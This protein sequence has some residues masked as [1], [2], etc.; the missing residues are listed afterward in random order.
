VNWKQND[1]WLG[2]LCEVSEE[3]SARSLKRAKQ[4]TLSLLCWLQTEV[5][6]PDGGAGWRGLR[7]HKDT[8]GTEDGLAKYR[9]IR[10][11]RRIKA[12]FAVLEKHVGTEAR[13]RLTGKSR[14]EVTAETFADSVSVGSYRI[15][16]RPSS[17]ET[18]YIVFGSLP[19]QISLGAL[20]PERVEN[21][22]VECK[23]IEK[24]HIT[25]G[26]YR[27]HPPE[28]NIG[29]SAGSLDTFCVGKKGKPRQVRNTPSLLV[30]F[31]RMI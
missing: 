10:E 5:P 29:E 26:C 13:M 2:N 6:R 21:P 30:E 16:L 18:S 11:S 1:Y 19:C 22:R 20:I 23:N 31:R 17:E 15:D 3:E 12:E 28:W 24:T 25:N 4:L 14:Y 8:V 9:Y 27:L 7:L